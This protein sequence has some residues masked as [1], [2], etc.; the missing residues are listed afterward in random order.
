MEFLD[1]STHSLVEIAAWFITVLL[2]TVGLAFIVYQLWAIRRE[3]TQKPALTFFFGTFGGPPENRRKVQTIQPV[4]SD[5]ALSEPIPITLFTKNAGHR[6][7]HDVMWNYVMEPDR[8]TLRSP[9]VNDTT[10]TAGGTL[11]CINQPV[12]AL[13]FIA[14]AKHPI[15][16]ESIFLHELPIQVSPDVKSILIRCCAWMS[17]SPQC[18]DQLQLSIRPASSETSPTL[19]RTPTNIS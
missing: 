15:H 8:G 11:Q 1:T 2:G 10:E 4:W 19:G 18:E 5:N 7:G 16:P 12:E 13:R 14:A 6:S 9:S 17:D 3:L